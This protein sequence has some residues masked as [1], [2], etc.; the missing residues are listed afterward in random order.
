[1]ARVKIGNRVYRSF[2]HLD[3]SVDILARM[4]AEQFI[5]FINNNA[6]I[7]LFIASLFNIAIF[8]FLYFKLR[9]F[10]KGSDAKTLEDKILRIFDENEKIKKENS[11]I[12]DLLLKIL[13]REKGAL[14]AVATVRFN[15]F[16]D[17][18]HGR[19]SF[20]SAV[21]NGKGDGFIIS[22]LSLHGETHV[23]LKDIDSFSSDK[24]LSQEEQQ[25]LEKARKK[26]YND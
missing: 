16:G 25:A 12:K 15:P 3:L 17:S 18:G 23:F 1:M 13:E 24:T 4:S 20:V 14:R 26:L 6:I 5:Y 9:R 19:Q 8:L 22:A 21:L 2:L 11:E 10:T 7:I